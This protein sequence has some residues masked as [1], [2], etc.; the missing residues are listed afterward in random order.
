MLSFY[1]HSVISSRLRKEILMFY[2][3]SSTGAKRSARALQKS[4]KESGLKLAHGQVLNA[5]ARMTG[6][7]D[8]NGLS[9][10]YSIEAVTAQLSESE[11]THLKAANSPDNVYDSEMS[12]LTHSG[13][14]LHAPAYPNEV[15]YVRV[16]DPLGR[17]VAYWVADEW[18]EAPQEV[19]GAILGALQRGVVPTV[20]TV[21]EL[22]SVFSVRQVPYSR[23]SGGIIGGDVFS[24][25]LCIE[26]D[27]HLVLDETLPHGTDLDVPVMTFFTIDGFAPR[28]VTAKELLALRW[29]HGC[30]IDENGSPWQFFVN[31]DVSEM[32]ANAPRSAVENAA[33]ELLKAV[34]GVIA[35]GGEVPSLTLD[36]LETL[37]AKI[38]GAKSR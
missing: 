29:D 38:R 4:L 32:R 2:I 3:N 30:F 6:F 24:D 8:W 27:I 28:D 21:R 17:E 10:S 20:Q 1:V 5:L 18:Q 22:A 12:L 16:L 36:E 13:F 9:A 19:M 34:E 7:E 26:E 23:L 11:Q 15:D 14:A 31:Q 37:V 25:A 33:P 35:L